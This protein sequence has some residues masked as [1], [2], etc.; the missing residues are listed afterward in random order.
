[1]AAV[2]RVTATAMLSILFCTAILGPWL[3]PHD[4]LEVHLSERLHRPSLR[5]PLGTDH[6]GRCVFS[7]MLYGARLSLGIAAAVVA[8]AATL[9]SLA[10]LAA[11]YAAGWLDPLLMRTAD[12]MLAIPALVLSL[13]IAG[14]LG[15][16]GLSVIL[17]LSMTGWTRY[18]R[19]V[20]GVVRATRRRM[21]VDAT[22]V[23][24]A[25]QVYIAFR[26]VLPEAMPAILVLGALET[27]TVILTVASLGF[28]G[29]GLQPPAP[30]WGSMLQ[31]GRYYLRAAPHLVL[32]PG[33]AILLAVASFQHLAERL[34]VSLHPQRIGFAD[35][36]I[37]PPN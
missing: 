27:G 28:L 37:A 29:L 20:R 9:G 19:A 30:E 10:G 24:G 26:R 16:G 34:R 22:R 8:V 31:D 18:A 4:P 6:L 25:S 15:P 2:V 14:L 23:L 7:R 1:M 3:A 35:E 36:T 13:F 32:F 33:A 11:G 21:F 12:A 17:A 5:Y